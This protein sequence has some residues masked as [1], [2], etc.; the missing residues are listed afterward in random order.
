M[1]RIFAVTVVA[2][3]MTLSAGFN[4]IAGANEVKDQDEK[5]ANVNK[6]PAKDKEAAVEEGVTIINAADIQKEAVK[7]TEKHEK[8]DKSLN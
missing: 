5:M 8:A 6:T 2:L 4:G 7:M 1:R 3:C